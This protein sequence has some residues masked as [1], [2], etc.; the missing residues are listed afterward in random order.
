MLTQLEAAKNGEITSVVE[1]AAEYEGLAPELLRDEIAAGRLVVPA[2]VMHLSW[3]LTPRAI[4]RKVSTKV[5]ANIGMSD[6]RSGIDAE[7]AKMAVAVEAGA[8]AVM[9]LS[10]GGDLDY[11]R[12]ELISAC[13]LPFGTVPIYEAITGRSVEDITPELVLEIAEKQAKQGVDFFTIHAGLLREH[14]P[15]LKSRVC[16]IVSRGGALTA[17][18]MLHHNRQ[19]L[20]YELFDELCDI[21]HEYDV[22]FSLGDGLRPGCGADATDDAQIAELRTLGELTQRAWEKGCQV[23]VEGPGHVPFNQIEENMRLQQEIC[24]NAPFYVLG[25]LVT[26]IAPGYDHITSAI[27]GTAAAY[28]GA[29]F[30]CYVTPREHLGLPDN[31][32][33]RQGVVASK[34]A[35]HSADVARG[36]NDSAQRDRRLSKARADLDWDTQIRLSLDPKTAKRMKDDASKNSAMSPEQADYCTMCGRDW[37]SVRINREI[38]DNL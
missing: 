3:N 30:L 34:I 38:R 23:M 6:V 12:S 37:C 20:M 29:S 17:K 35:A 24:N 18:W 21:M 13:P 10:T 5:N 25:P 15:L 33:V 16:G 31:E 8:D 4:G 19:N 9:D 7:K 27:G 14:L 28:Y 32:D 26:D 1:N 22:C 11:V 36:H 2:N